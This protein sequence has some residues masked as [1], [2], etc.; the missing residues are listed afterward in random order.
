MHPSLTS[1]KSSPLLGKA[2]RVKD[3]SKIFKYFLKT[4]CYLLDD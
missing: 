2:H 3:P 1:R 4:C